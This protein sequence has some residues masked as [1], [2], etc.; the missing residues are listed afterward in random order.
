MSQK[1]KDVVPTH[2][3]EGSQSNAE[4]RVVASYHHHESKDE[5]FQK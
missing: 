4:P 5:L 3:S 1:P 2:A